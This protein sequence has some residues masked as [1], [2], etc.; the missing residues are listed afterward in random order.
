VSPLHRTWLSVRP[1]EVLECTG[2]HARTGPI[3]TQT[4]HGRSGSF[5]AAY[6]GAT[7]TGAAFPGTVVTI[8]PEAGDSMARARSRAGSSCI[9]P[10]TMTERCGLPAL[11][12]SANVVYDEVWRPGALPT[13]SFSY[14]YQDL[15]T[16][17]PASPGACFPTWQVTCRITIH[18]A[19]IGMRAGH[20]HPLWSVPRPLGGVDDGMGNI[21]FPQT[22]TTCHNRLAADGMTPQLPAASLELTD[23]ISDQDAL[24]LRAYRQ[25]LFARDELELDAMGAVVP[26]QVPGPPDENGN[27]TFTI[28]QLPPSMAAQ[29]ARGSRF[30][31][32]MNNNTHAGMLSPAE[33]RLLSEWLDIGAQYYNDPFPP[34]PQN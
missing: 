24:Q 1:G 26:R 17:S 9:D 6:Q 33:L 12:P 16:D 22:C 15:T 34:T 13:E 28:P 27:P 10:V 18:Y 25:L 32:V 11:T 30:F 5:N 19:A 14:R 20:I 7:A 21:T 8:S 4:S 23:E 2:C 3:A 31:A 29:N